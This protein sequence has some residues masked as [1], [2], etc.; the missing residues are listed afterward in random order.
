MLRG[1]LLHLLLGDRPGL[2]ETLR[3]V[4]A[5]RG[6]LEHAGGGDEGG[7]RLDEIGAVDR[8]QALALGDLIADFGK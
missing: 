2:V 8:E 3:P 5:A 7:F 4:Q 6:Q 1:R